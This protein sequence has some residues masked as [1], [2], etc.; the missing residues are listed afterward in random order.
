MLLIAF[1]GIVVYVIGRSLIKVY[2]Y[3]KPFR[4]RTPFYKLIDPTLIEKYNF[5]NNP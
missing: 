4:N 5:N 2:F 1:F 3:F